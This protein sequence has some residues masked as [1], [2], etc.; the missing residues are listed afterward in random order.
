MAYI[1]DSRLQAETV[2]RIHFTGT[3]E[4]QFD[5]DEAFLNVHIDDDIDVDAMFGLD[6]MDYSED[7][8]A[9]VCVD[10]D[11]AHEFGAE[12]VI[13]EEGA[14]DSELMHALRDAL[15][16]SADRHSIL[17]THCNALGDHEQASIESLNALHS[18]AISDFVDNSTISKKTYIAEIAAAFRPLIEAGRVDELAESISLASMAHPDAVAASID[19]KHD[20][21][22]DLLLSEEVREDVESGTFAN[23]DEWRGT[24]R[25]DASSSLD[26]LAADALDASS[27]FGSDISEHESDHVRLV[28]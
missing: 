28:R 21:L 11:Y 6:V 20:S 1:E 25:G 2:D 13:I 3:I 17:V 8:L 15:I 22:V 27:S 16:D 12:K 26:D 5:D 9:R 10:F 18:I 24:Y 14:S 19:R 23:L 4:E 7:D